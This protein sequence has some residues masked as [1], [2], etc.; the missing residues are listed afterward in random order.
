MKRFNQI[1]ILLLV[2]AVCSCTWLNSVT[3][4]KPLNAKQQATVWVQVYNSTYDS[5]MATM[6][7]PLSTPAQ[8]D[9]AQKK[10]AI[11]AKAW[12]IL[13]I[14]VSVVEIGGIPTAQD[15]AALTDL[16]DQ[17]V[18]LAGGSL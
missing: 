18:V 11:L 4:T 13:K 12:P 5:T 15:T 1:S 16:F 8:K 6:T 9:M 17:L 3:G 14:Y 10:K 7:N 2:M